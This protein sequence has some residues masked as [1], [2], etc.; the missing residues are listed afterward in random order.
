[1]VHAVLLHHVD[2]CSHRSSPTRMML[3]CPHHMQASPIHACTELH[4][5]SACLHSSLEAAAFASVRCHSAWVTC[6]LSAPTMCHC[7]LLPPCSVPADAVGP[8]QQGLCSTIS[9]ARICGLCVCKLS[10]L[11]GSMEL[12][13]L[14]GLAAAPAETS[15]LSATSMV[16]STCICNIT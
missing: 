6:A 9:R 2:G 5:R 16:C 4:F 11:S 12:Y 1:M 13:G 7:M 15:Y 8:K 10:A 3:H 14:A